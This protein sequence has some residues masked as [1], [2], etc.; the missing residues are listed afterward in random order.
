MTKIDLIKYGDNYEIDII[1]LRKVL[2]TL[3][4]LDTKTFN[5]STKRWIIPVKDAEEFE[6]LFHGIAKVEIKDGREERT[7][8]LSYDIDAENE[9]IFVSVKSFPKIHKALEP[10]FAYFK[11]I[12]GKVYKSLH[13]RWKFN[14]V[15][16]KESKDGIRKF[17]DD[18]NIIV[19]F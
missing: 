4:R 10:L 18:N 7:A 6:K 12:D 1:P 15:H 11:S 17:S 3:Y 19:L 13:K 9:K 14:M 5:K 16:D 8:V 2:D